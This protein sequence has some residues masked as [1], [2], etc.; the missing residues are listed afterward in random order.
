VVFL[1]EAI[2]VGAGNGVP[3]SNNAVT[4]PMRYPG[5]IAAI[6]QQKNNHQTYENN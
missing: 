6:P 5:L 3:K 4:F 1:W 2:A